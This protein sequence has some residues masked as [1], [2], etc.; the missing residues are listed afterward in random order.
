MP[1]RMGLARKISQLFFDFGSAPP[2]KPAEG[3]PFE[4]QADEATEP[5]AS[6]PMTEIREMTEAQELTQ[7]CQA[8]LQQLQMPGMAKVVRVYWNPRM[9]ST[10]GYASYPS[11]RIELNPRLREFDGQTDRTLRHELAHL[12]AYHRAG[13]RRI[14]PHGPEWRQACVD[15]GIPG[16]SARHTL[17][18]PRRQMQRNYVYACAH[19]GLIVHRVR[20]FRRGTA[21]RKCCDAHNGGQFDVK[22]RFVLIEKAAGK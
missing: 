19:C 1:D 6:E 11:W 3:S 2:W 18:L 22:Y 10:A 12:I 14:E 20:K 13:R 17:P 15:V 7:L 21:C 5:A 9:R 16:E 8:L 4:R